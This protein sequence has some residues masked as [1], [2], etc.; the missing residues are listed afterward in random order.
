[1]PIK[2]CGMIEKYHR[3]EYLVPELLKPAVPTISERES[4]I[5]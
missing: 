2:D 1:M 5:Y 4:K 3:I